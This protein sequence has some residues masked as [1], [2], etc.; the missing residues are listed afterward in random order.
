MDYGGVTAQQFGWL[1]T[2]EMATEMLCYIPVAHWADKY[3]RRPFVVATFVFFTFFPIALL[4]ARRFMLL[5]LAFVV[6]GLK[7]R[8]NTKFTGAD[9]GVPRPPLTE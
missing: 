8:L 2:I 3:G 4:F 7:E 9:A 5:A 6:R 1:V